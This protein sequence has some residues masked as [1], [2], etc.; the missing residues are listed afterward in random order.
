[1]LRD[2]KDAILKAKMAHNDETTRIIQQQQH[3]ANQAARECAAA[4]AR[5]GSMLPCLRPG[6]GI[7]QEFDGSHESGQW[8][9]SAAGAALHVL[10]AHAQLFNPVL[11]HGR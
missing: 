11:F 10:L 3:L 6:A 2:L 7:P 1:M 8:A 5:L 9:N 4:S